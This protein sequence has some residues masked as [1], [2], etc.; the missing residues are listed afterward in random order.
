MRYFFTS[1]THFGHGDIIEYANRPF[2]TPDEMNLTLIRNWNQRVKKEDTVF[3]LGDFCFKS[4]LG[5]EKAEFWKSQLN[6]NIIFV[7]GNH[8]N[9]NSLKTN[10]DCIHITHGGKR[11]NLCHKPEHANPEF[12]INFVGHV[13]NKWEIRSFAE[14]YKIIHNLVNNVLVSDS[15]DWESFLSRNLNYY[16]SNSILINVGVDVNKFMP[17]TFEEL[18]GK[19]YK[20]LKGRKNA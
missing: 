10:I 20:S 19:Y 16:R 12:E 4:G 5:C 18:M 17:V 3:F 9:N 1:D 14:H 6:G 11:I 7:R 2:K 13:H 15:Q 8:D